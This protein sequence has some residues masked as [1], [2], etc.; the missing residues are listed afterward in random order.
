MDRQ[1]AQILRDLWDPPDQNLSYAAAEIF[2]N[3]LD[4]VEVSA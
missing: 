4:A 3:S 1:E 2:R